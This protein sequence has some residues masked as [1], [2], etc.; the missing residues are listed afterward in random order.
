MA[1]ALHGSSCARPPEAPRGKRVL[2][3][4]SYPRRGKLTRGFGFHGTGFSA[5][6]FIFA[7]LSLAAL[8]ISVARI[9]VYR[10]SV[11]VGFA[12]NNST[13]KSTVRCSRGARVDCPVLGAFTVR[14]SRG[15]RIPSGRY[16]DRF[17]SFHS[18]HPARGFP[19]LLETTA[20]HLVT[21]GTHDDIAVRAAQGRHG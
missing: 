8:G 10:D 6:P 16:R 15:A 9:A 1:S 12:P 20:E 19:L 21:Q 13:Q 5:H 3:L 4:V 2:L 7:G 17:G 11:L 14:C 18:A